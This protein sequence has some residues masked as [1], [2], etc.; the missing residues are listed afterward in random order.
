MKTYTKETLAK[1]IYSVLTRTFNLRTSIVCVAN[2]KIDSQNGSLQ[3]KKPF[4]SSREVAMMIIWTAL[5]AVGLLI[6]FSQYI[7]GPG[8]ITVSIILLPVYCKLLK[9]IPAMI[10]GTLGM[11][12]AGFAGAAIVPTFGPFSFAMPIV[13]GLLGSLSF[14]YRW[15]A[16]PGIAFLGAAGY[17]YAVFSGGT[18]LWLVAYGVAIAAGIVATIIY[19]PK[20]Q[21]TVWT[22]ASW[23]IV[24]GCCIYLT[25][26]IE[27]ATMNLGSIFYLNLTG[28]V[29]TLITPV[30]AV[31]RTIVLIVAFTILTA[32]WNRLR[33][34]I[35]ELAYV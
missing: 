19:V 35:G 13:A 5:Y 16:I 11:A 29:W 22:K 28:P 4:M 10:A 32:L 2:H 21:N 18:L 9:P 23:Y 30:S 20:E 3:R 27:N 34:K 7:G 6:P 15:G 12:I 24:T 31:E 14:N 33:G 26:I 8:F 17:L 25:T 1:P